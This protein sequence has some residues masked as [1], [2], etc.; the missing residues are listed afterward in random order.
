MPLCCE[1]SLRTASRGSFSTCSVSR[2]DFTAIRAFKA[3][4]LS[5]EEVASK[6]GVRVLPEIAAEPPP[7]GAGK[8]IPWVANKTEKNQI[9]ATFRGD[10]DVCS[11]EF[12]AVHKLSSR[13]DCKCC[14]SLIGKPQ[15]YFR[16]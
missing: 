3:T 9:M 8:Q 13:N 16:H 10:I 11:L 15:E 4:D 1:I 7:G 2:P 5:K 6:V 14:D 12:F